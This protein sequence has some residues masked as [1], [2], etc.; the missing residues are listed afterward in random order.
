MSNTRT[1][2]LIN[3]RITQVLI[4]QYKETKFNQRSAYLKYL[5]EHFLNGLTIPIL[6]QTTSKIIIELND[7]FGFSPETCMDFIKPYF[8]NKKYNQFWDI[9]KLYNIIEEIEI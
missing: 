7:V 4:K 1:Y 6:V 3:I 9:A 5:S 2:D 8:I